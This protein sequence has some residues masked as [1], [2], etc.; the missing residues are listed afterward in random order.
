MGKTES[1]HNN[2]DIICLTGGKCGLT[3]LLE[4]FKFQGFNCIKCHNH[5]DFISQFGYDGLY[6]SIEDSSKNKKLYIIDSYRTPI[7]RK[8]SSFFHHIQ[9][10]IPYYKNKSIKELINIFNTE[11]LNNI[12]EYHPVD[13][14]MLELG[15]E[16]FNSFDFKKKYVKKEKGNL[17]FIKILFSDIKDW[18]NILSEIFNKKII[19]QKDN[20][21]QDKE[22]HL[23]YEEFKKKYKTTK[24]YLNNILR[25]DKYFKI[26]NTKEQQEKYIEKYLKSAY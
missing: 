13:L 26:Y 3:T 7:E 18:E 5:W 1:L 24:S 25:N 10:K 11:Y 2:L 22:Y 20:L 17:I 19:I 16:S 15:C 9:K 21:S 6:N 14:I 23:I 4:T 12:E 8:I